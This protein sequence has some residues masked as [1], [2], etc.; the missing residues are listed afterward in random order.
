M[1][2]LL[3][4]CVPRKLKFLLP[5]HD[6]RTVQEMGWD[7]KRNGAL[8]AA[9]DKEFDL[10]LT[11]DRGYEYQQNLTGL[12]ISVMV[13]GGRSNTYDS[14]APLAPAIREAISRLGTGVVV[15]VS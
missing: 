6:S 10:L 9:A 2:I 7:G 3:D 4:E 14:L 11:A 8:L 15:R 12:H 5:D 1:R 13:L